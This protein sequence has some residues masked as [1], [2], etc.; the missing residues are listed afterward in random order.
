MHR[1][2]LLIPFA[3]VTFDAGVAG[4]RHLFD[5]VV[6]CSALGEYDGDD[7]AVEGERLGEDHHEDEG[8]Q[9]IFLG[10]ATHAGVTDNANA[11]AGGE[12]AQTAAQASAERP[13][14]SCVAVSPGGGVLEGFEA[15]LRGGDWSQG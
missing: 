12:V 11:E 2:D 9:D 1:A 4:R 15:V 6:D 5:L 13:I 14:P 10:I 7:E 3:V 8:D